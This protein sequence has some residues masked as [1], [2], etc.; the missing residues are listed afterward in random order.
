MAAWLLSILLLASLTGGLAATGDDA[1]AEE[2]RPSAG[3]LGAT[4]GIIGNSEEPPERD[5][6]VSTLKGSALFTELSSGAHDYAFFS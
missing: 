3:T 6:S 4:T 1:S 5:G 2:I